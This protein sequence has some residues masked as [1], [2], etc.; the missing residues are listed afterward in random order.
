MKSVLKM[1]ICLFSI[2]I[3]SAQ[4]V[5]LR[6]TDYAGGKTSIVIEPFNIQGTTDFVTK[7]KNIESIIRFDLDYSLYFDILSDTNAFKGNP[8][9]SGVILRASGKEP[10]LTLTLIDFETKQKIGEFTSPLSGELRH[11]AHSL[12]DKI[13]ETITGEKG[14]STTKIV[15]SYI[16]GIGKELAMIDYDGYNFIQLTNN[17]N[18]N[19]FPCWAPDGN[20]ILYS[21]YIKDRLNLNLLDINQKKLTIISTYAGLNYAPDWS[22][23][24]TKIALTLTKDGNA[25]IYLLDLETKQLHR[26]TNNRAIDCSPVFSPNGREIAF[27]S[28]RSGMPQIYIMDIYGGNVRR[29]TFHGDYNTSPA[30]SPRG[31]LIAYVSRQQNY[32][33]QICV[34]D[35]YDFQPIQLTF[36]GNNE[37]PSWSPDGLHIVFISNRTGQ[38]ELWTMNWDGTRQ[39]KLTQGLVA[40]SPA[41]S[42]FLR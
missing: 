39:R 14:I 1:L 4:E 19:L 29:L 27:V 6:L 18:F 5:Y 7:I 11:Y 16:S 21:T 17:N 15:F 33:Q 36:E 13:I 42:P 24:G 22:R 26:L 38:Y 28:D 41:W 40:Y 8:K 23:D 30:W 34:T 37:E 25:E 31:D 35:P 32:S 12:S 3:I 10:N 20:R 9:K 2:C